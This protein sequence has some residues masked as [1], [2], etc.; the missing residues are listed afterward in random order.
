MSDNRD[1]KRVIFT[2]KN[3]LQVGCLKEDGFSSVME[4]AKAFY[5]ADTEF[6][7]VRVAQDQLLLKRLKTLGDKQVEQH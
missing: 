3:G 6:A 4:V 2:F 7:P 1:L 5:K